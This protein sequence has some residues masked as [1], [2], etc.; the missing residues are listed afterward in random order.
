MKP[1]WYFFPEPSPKTEGWNDPAAQHFTGHQVKGLVRESI[2]NSLDNQAYPPQKKEKTKTPVIVKFELFD[3][4]KNNI[5]D[6]ETYKKHLEWIKNHSVDDEAKEGAG[7]ALS[8]LARSKVRVLKIGDYN[9]KG[10]SGSDSE[11][12]SNWYRLVQSV[13]SSQKRAGSGGSFGIGKSSFLA[14]SALRMIF[15]STKCFLT[16]KHNF[17]GISR[18][19]T[20]HFE[21][22][23]LQEKGYCS[24]KP[25]KAISDP[26]K[27]P[28]LFKREDPG[29][30]V[31]VFGLRTESIS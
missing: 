17:I 29:L 18:L 13:G 31:F 7:E 9:T 30:D 5:P 24:C 22:D 11:E 8:T 20:H 2:Q 27:I 19:C 12:N 28:K 15:F 26:D 6:L 10:A 21:K 23:K 16:K 14:N 25:G 1:E 3:I 4:D